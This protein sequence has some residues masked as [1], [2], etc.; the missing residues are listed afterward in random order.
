MVKS[1]LTI[2][3]STTPPRGEGYLPVARAASIFAVVNLGAAKKN[4]SRPA[5]ATK[6]YGKRRANWRSAPN[7]TISTNAPPIKVPIGKLPQAKKR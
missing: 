6:K 3:L 5:A 1:A 7:S 4:N 2:S